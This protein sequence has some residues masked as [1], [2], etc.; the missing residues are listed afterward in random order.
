MSRRIC[1]GHT[2][3]LSVRA[4]CHPRDDLDAV[5]THLGQVICHVRTG[6]LCDRDN[7]GAPVL[8]IIELRLKLRRKL[9]DRH[10]NILGVVLPRVRGRRRGIRSRLR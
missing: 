4:V 1:L 2:L 7:V 9:A 6:P 3:G 8:L 10:A 5:S